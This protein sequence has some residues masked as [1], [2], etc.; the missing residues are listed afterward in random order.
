MGTHI[1]APQW[2]ASGE[3]IVSI[4]YNLRFRAEIRF[5]K[6]LF[7]ECHIYLKVQA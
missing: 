5:E 3:Y 2:G 1:E 7:V 4:I 6:S